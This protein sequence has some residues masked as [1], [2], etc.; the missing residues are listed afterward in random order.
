MPGA[1]VMMH[2]RRPSAAETTRAIGRQ[3]EGGEA[4]RIVCFGDSITGAYYHS[5]GTRA[6]PELL[7][8][9]LKRLYPGSRV[10]VI[11]AGVSGSI[12]RN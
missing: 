12:R 11:N 5:G 9:A 2:G 4:V 10:E 6:W 8:I 7:E 3:L 1:P